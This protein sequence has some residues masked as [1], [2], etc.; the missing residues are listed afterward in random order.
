MRQNTVS[1]ITIG[2]ELLIGQT[3]DTN[4]AWM[5]KQLN[6]IGC[7]IK[8]RI[9][10]GDEATAIVE[11]LDQTGKDS[12]IVL[13][14]GGLGP[15]ADDIT[16]PVLC[17]Y[18]GGKLIVNEEK[19]QHIAAIFKRSNRPVL[20]RNLLQATVPDNCIPLH[21]SRGTA[22]GMWFEKGG[23]IYISM[24]GVP[25]EMMGIMEEDVLPRLIERLRLP[26]VIH[27]NII[28]SGIG[29]SFLAELIK[30]FE[31]SLPATIK[32]AYLPNFGMV[33]LRLSSEG[34]AA[35]S[36]VAEMNKLHAQLKQLVAPYFV[37]DEDLSIQE[38]VSMELRRRK[39]TLSTAESCT[40][41]YIGH[42]VTGLPGAS[43]IFNGGIISY[44]NNAK[45]QALGVQP[46]TIAQNGAV[47]EATAE[48]MA[49]GALQRLNSDYVI[50]VSGVMG[51]GGGSVE[52]PV[53]MVVIATGNAASI[54][55][56]TYYLRYNRSRN[57]EQ[58]AILALNQLRTF[59]M[60]SE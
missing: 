57:I 50:A 36:L 33:K 34:S 16:K 29:E 45:I 15:T 1:I 58:T 38:I 30:D 20:E 35:A 46:E 42:L 48:E 25:F 53:G 18:F 27:K 55:T 19:R 41:G 40:G 9:A 44:H 6:S 11:A 3:I 21:N 28:T 39:K 54:I 4:S 7:V 5:A 8:R 51:P 22:P 59:M 26:P 17:T 37:A 2:D 56:R 10:I 14:T 23:V 32:L 12:D 47:S 52:K 43:E 13:L 49:A 60:Q 31:S 24:P